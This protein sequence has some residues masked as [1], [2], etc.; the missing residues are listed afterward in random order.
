[1]QKLILFGLGSIGQR[2]LRLILKHWPGQF[3]I[4]AFRHS[5]TGNPSQDPKK[6]TEVTTWPQVEEIMPGIAFICNPTQYHVKTALKCAELGCDL[7]IEKPLSHDLVGINELIGTIK[8]KRLKN[9]VA[10]PFRHHSDINMLKNH[11]NSTEDAKN[12]RRIEKEVK[13]VAECVKD[14]KVEPSGKI[15]AIQSEIVCRSDANRWPTVRKSHK[16]GGGVLLELSHELDLA[17][18]LFG[19]VERIEGETKCRSD[20]AGGAETYA[21]LILHHVSGHKVAITLDMDAK[22][23]ERYIKMANP[24][25]FLPYSADDDLYLVQLRYFF[26]TEASE[27]G[28]TVEQ[29]A[30]LL[31]QIINFRNTA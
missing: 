16:N 3:D 6:V 21:E 25:T 14:K 28:N 26:D 29:A 30:E 12:G 8:A 13:T 15:E 11:L 24:A 20:V 23:E 27:I 22:V 7:C 2:H 5:S 4:Y 1:M 18:Y 17:T 9:Y 10:Y 19:L 31:R